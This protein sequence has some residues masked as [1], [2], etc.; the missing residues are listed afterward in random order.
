[1]IYYTIP[2]SD[3]RSGISGASLNF[4]WFVIV[5]DTGIV[6]VS[7][8]LRDNRVSLAHVI[9]SSFRAPSFSMSDFLEHGVC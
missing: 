8:A 5:P 4:T 9:E 1:M 2:A 6:E 3:L 7:F